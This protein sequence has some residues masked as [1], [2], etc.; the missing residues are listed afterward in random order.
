MWHR[1][2]TRYKL[3]PAHVLVHTSIEQE[4]DLIPFHRV[5]PRAA[6]IHQVQA[7]ALLG[8]RVGGLDE[9]ITDDDPFMSHPTRGHRYRPLRD[10][11]RD[12]SSPS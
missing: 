3:G 6:K 2:L 9:R 12:K 4:D 8:F 1:I 7:L 10:G 5:S 11:D